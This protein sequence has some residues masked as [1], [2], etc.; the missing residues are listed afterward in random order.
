ME[1]AGTENET[2]QIVAQILQEAL[3]QGPGQIVTPTHLAFVY[4]DC[5][6]QF[7]I[8]NI[9]ELK[10]KLNQK[11]QAINLTPKIVFLLKIPNWENKRHSTKKRISC[12]ADGYGS[13]KN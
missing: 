9:I 1:D 2:L 5:N 11:Y 7:K 3:T 8:R 4:Y 10:E 6:L 13:E 12:I